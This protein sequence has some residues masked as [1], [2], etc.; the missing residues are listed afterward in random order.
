MQMGLKYHIR[1]IDKYTADPG[2]TDQPGRGVGVWLSPL[3]VPTVP[4]F[5]LLWHFRVLN[6]CF[7][8]ELVWCVGFHSCQFPQ[9]SKP[10]LFSRATE[11]VHGRSAML[12]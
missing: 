12:I 1:E 2:H 9:L 10:A 6:C 4:V 11:L 7:V 8:S 3:R 5:I